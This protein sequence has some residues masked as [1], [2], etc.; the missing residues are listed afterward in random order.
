MANPEHLAKLMEGVE[1]WNNWRKGKEMASVDLSQL[2]LS[3]ADFSGANFTM[4]NFYGSILINTNLQG[5]DFHHADLSLTIFAGANLV[6]ADFFGAKFHCSDI[7][8]ANFANAFFGFTT[9]SNVNLESVKG[10]DSVHHKVE[11]TIGID[12]IFISKGKIPES[13]L[14]GCGV[15]QVFIGYI[16]ALVGAIQ[17]IEFY[18]V[19]ISYSSKDQAFAERLH[20]DLQ[21]KKVR[22]WFAPED[23]KIGD[24][25]RMKIDEC[26]RLYDKLLLV[27]SDYSVGSDWVEKEVETALEK[28]RQ[29]K[30]TMLFPIRLDD[31]VMKIEAGWPADV[32]RTRH[33]GDFNN[34]KDHDQYQKAFNRLIR[35]LK[36]DDKIRA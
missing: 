20:A 10:L 25:F 9:L 12:T 27:L 5:A 8:D 23:L 33:I 35:D 36:A 31:S 34:W 26:I 3:G 22:C 28:E 30:R 17:P 13:F 32:R 14:R 15:P 1:A 11:S 6:G 29:Q 18:S 24:K 19:F 21:S 4:A 16:P 7:R 2:N